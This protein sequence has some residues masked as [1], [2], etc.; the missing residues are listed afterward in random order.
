MI[1]TAWKV[2]FDGYGPSDYDYASL[3]TPRIPDDALYQPRGASHYD[4][5]FADVVCICNESGKSCKCKYVTTQATEYEEAN[6]LKLKP[7]LGV[8]LVK[9][10][11]MPEP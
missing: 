2:R 9:G 6:P 8:S 4:G 10:C 5:S 1:P 3:I 7:A 11:G